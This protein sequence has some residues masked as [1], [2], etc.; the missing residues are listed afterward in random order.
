MPRVSGSVR[1]VP[2]TSEPEDLDGYL[3][4][5]QARAAVLTQG[6]GHGLLGPTGQR[7]PHCRL[8]PTEQ[9]QPLPS[10]ADRTSR[11]RPPGSQVRHALYFNV[12]HEVRHLSFGQY[13]PGMHNPL[14]NTS[15]HSAEGAAEARYMI[16]ARPRP[17]PPDPA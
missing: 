1:I 9:L 4:G 3:P 2:A 17:T 13:F 5:F 14:D 8:G 7:T 10:R 11:H 12:S 16:K 15:K 6:H